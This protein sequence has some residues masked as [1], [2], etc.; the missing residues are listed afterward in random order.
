MAAVLTPI[1][2]ERAHRLVRWI[3]W[4]KVGAGMGTLTKAVG[5][6]GGYFQPVIIDRRLLTPSNECHP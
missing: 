3:N 1:T 5:G 2:S 6:L 4:E